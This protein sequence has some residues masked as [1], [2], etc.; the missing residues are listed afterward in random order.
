MRITLEPSSETSPSRSQTPKDEVEWVPL[1]KHPLFT[2]HGGATVS[3]YRN[4]LA[5]D[6]ASRLYFWDTN[7]RILHRLSLR[8]GDPDPS[9]VLASSPSKVLQAD[10]ELDFDV[11]KISV[12]RNGTAILLFGSE[13]LS[14]MYLYGRASKNDVNLICRTITVGS[15]TYSTG[16]NDIRVLQALWHPYSDTHLGILSSDSVFRLFNLAVDPLQPEQEYY[17]QPVEPGRLRNASSVCPV[18][19]SF[20]G[21]HLWD[22]FSVF[23]LF[24]NGAIYV[25]CPVVPFGSLFK[26][27]SLVEIY[28]DAHTFGIISANSVAASNSKLAISW[29]EAAFPE[30]QNQDTE[31]DSLSL[32]RARAY[33]LFDASLVLQG[34]LQRVGQDGNG[35]SVGCSTECE[36]RAVSF[37]YNLVSKDSILVTAWSGGQ[38]QIDALADEIQPVWCVGSPPRLRVDSHDQILGLAMICESITCSS[39]GKVDHNA[40]LGNPPP[41]LRLAIV[42]LALPR[43]AESGYNI[44]LF[45]DMLMPERIFSLH[46]GGIDS[47]VL[48]FLP[49]TSQSNGKDDTMKTPSVH[50]VL[51]TCQSGYSSEPSFCGFVS[52]SDSFGY[53]WIVAITLSLECVVLEMK[54]WNLLLPVSID[55]EKKPISSEGVSKERDIP[56]II[57]KELLSGPKEVLVPHASPSLRSVAAD[58][59]EGRSTL[60]QYFKLFHETYVEY[61][62]KVYLELKHHAPQLNKIINDQ[63][64]RLGEAQQ[65]LLNVEKK[66]AI[67]QKRLDRAIQ[68]HNSLEE[69]LQQLRNLPCAH[70][71]P[72]STAERQFKSEL[73]RFK[74]VE[75]DAL[76]SSVDAVSARLR[77]HLQASKANQQ[78]K[79]AGKKIHAVDSQ[80]SMLK[81]SLEK[82]SLVNTD[83]SKKVKL[84]ESTL[85]NK[86]R[87]SGKE[88]SLPLP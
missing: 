14:V 45:I 39:L 7:S 23:I 68:M 61:G 5:W 11:H 12:N 60:H 33:S 86:E 10:A 69:R 74:E 49:F 27:E 76:H 67:L 83:N 73:D 62:H 21:D 59:I 56:T 42:D 44:S 81:S 52:L 82:L 20:G 72:L 71:K 22:R 51:N 19:F 37:L 70:K 25:L 15:Q 34:P 32:L 43:R 63:H 54:S 30:L 17:L 78:Q 8:L 29:L 75:L 28:N 66:E 88:S 3:G 64:S 57:S 77:R 48:H 40:W 31:G 80:I 26:C 9:S 24:S 2:A 53:S 79:T 18:D 46:D 87:S 35:D 47:I 36:G 85:R 38:L 16:G 58:S 6:G 65:K 41:L 55:M 13:R 84:V 1:P 50:P 4:I